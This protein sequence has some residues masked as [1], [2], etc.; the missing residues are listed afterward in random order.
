MNLVKMHSKNS[1]QPENL[2]I[3]NVMK[4]LHYE[5]YDTWVQ[6]FALNL[7]DIWKEDSASI[8]P[9]NTKAN[10]A[11]VIGRGPSLSNHNHLKMLAESDYKGAIVCC[12]GILSKALDCGVTPEKFPEFYV[13]TIDPYEHIGK[14]YDQ[15]I[16]SKFG[17]KIKGIFSVITNPNAV[18]VAR[19]TGIKIHW[20][21]SLFDYDEGKKS[22]NQTS[23]L[24]IRAKKHLH[25]LPA[26]QTGGNV[27]TSSWFAGWR[28]L[29][30]S[31]VC[32]IG[33]DHSWNEN[34]SWEKIVSH[35]RNIDPDR[36][37][38]FP[39]STI[40]LLNQ[41]SLFK[42][43]YNPFFKCTCILDP[44]FQFYSQALKEFILRSIDSVNTVN[45]TEGGSIFGQGITC[46]TFKEFLKDFKN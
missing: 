21:H 17:N 30:C 3:E 10:S 14:F 19:N 37:H 44:L 32:L 46:M 35:G 26:I 34:D 16:V 24:M 31:T 41:E 33:I 23:A 43:V 7:Q 39:N 1:P 13:V 22:F 15:E 25:G 5:S 18:E 38:E 45:A 20:I 27:G 12:D 40:D 6:N 2:I 28:I 42:K 29:K 4:K 9:N 11:V 36:K 8:L